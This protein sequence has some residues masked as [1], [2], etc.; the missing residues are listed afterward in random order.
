[1]G[2]VAHPEA[3]RVVIIGAGIV[4]VN[5]ADEL[6]E[7]GWSDITVVEQGPLSMPGGSTSHAPG[8]VFQTNPDRTMTNFAKYTVEKLLSISKDGQSCFN[9]V[10]GLEIATTPERFEDLKRKHGLAQSYGVEARVISKQECLDLYPLL[11]GEK[12][13]G[14]LH[15][16]S[17]GLALAARAVQ[18]LI[19]RT[20]A[21]GVRYLDMTP[22]T[23]IER[24]KGRVTGVTTSAGTVPADIVVSCGG[25][26]G[27]ELG[28]MVGL[29]VP[30]V[31][32]AHQ[33]AK[34][35]SVPALKGRNNPE[36]GASL[37]ILRYQDQDLYYREHGDQIGI[38]FYGHKPMPFV[39]ADLGVTAKEVDDKH[40]PSRL[41]FTSEDFEPAWKL[42][43]ELL[44]STRE[45]EIQ[46]GFNGLFSFTPDGGS[47]VGP[48]PTLEGFFVAEAVWVTH[49]A[50]VARAVAEVLT[51]GKSSFDLASSDINRFEEVQLS[52]AYVS[53]TSQQNFVEIY[54][55]LHPLQPKESPRALRASPFFPRQKDLGAFFLEGGAWERP[56]WYESNA[57]LL[58]AIPPEW[59]AP[60]RDA[61]AARYWSPIA[62]AEAWK[63]RTSV[64]MYD[65][66]PLRRLEV[67]GPGA[68]DLLQRASTGD[69]GK[70]PLPKTGP[71]TYTLWLDGEGGVRSDVTVARIEDEL[72]QV[73][74][75]TPVDTVY[76][77][78]EARKQAAKD[79][80]KWAH[81]KDITGGTCCI[82]LWGPL[83]RDVVAKVSSDNWSTKA[84]RYFRCK[85]VTIAGIPVTAMRL[86]YVGELGW[87][88][89]TSAEHGLRL[90][91]ALFKAG[92]EFG[93]VAAGRQAFNSLRLEKGYRAWG[94]DMTTE[95]DPF[96]AGVGFAV[97]LDK[98][99]GFVGSDA[100]QGR[101]VETSKKRLRCLTVD[102]GTSVV[103]GKEPVFHASS[104]KAVGYVTSAAYGYSV[105]KPI[106]YAWLPG[107]LGEE[108][109]VEI[110]YFGRR[111]KATITPEPLFDPKMERLRG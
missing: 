92:E 104:D 56:Y 23:G 110:E 86:S 27:V 108:E 54:D 24:A 47:L 102:D 55:I 44:P 3:K 29:R 18:I 106:A 61:W 77:K 87:E 51:T 25:F 78:E 109:S 69:V 19:E 45:V 63:T 38:G 22:V 65:M 70:K 57:K 16:P 50:G 28:A 7:R 97:K 13:V 41:S 36:N 84:L 11:D 83:A 90:W 96:E 37:P 111:I 68:A 46:D 80:S 85:R 74:C 9:Q 79:P 2:S 49:S 98:E 30:L 107:S 99:G 4:G 26:W 71:V 21:A 62:A 12:V 8:L 32:L 103:L 81:V 48:H 39:A 67:S 76:M 6:V 14:A 93:I 5:V 1:M 17:D 60:E 95:H 64:A 94:T 31:P 40:M 72:F 53:E 66:T 59:K 20:K 75:N 42:T 100:L 89:Y 73:G 52:E 33:Y 82:G 105:R 58:D 91:D 43:Q 88:L 10:G 35:T 15:I 101:S 34:T